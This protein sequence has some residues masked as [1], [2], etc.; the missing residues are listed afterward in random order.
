MRFAEQER[1]FRSVKKVLVAVS[2]GPDSVACLL[3]LLR[4]R[5]RFGLEVVVGHFDHQL[6]P[7]SSADLEFVRRLC[8]EHEIPCFTGEGDVRSVARESRANVEETA[9][10]MRYQFL[11]FVAGKENA[12][13]VATGHTSDDQA[14]TV[15]M[16]VV[17]G[18]GV[19]G[20]RGMLPAAS[21]PEGDALRLVRPLLPIRHADTVAICAE[22]GVEP[23]SD[24]TNRD[25]SLFRN[26]I[27]MEVLPRL[28]DVNPS[29]DDALLGLGASARQL[30]AAIER[31]SFEVQPVARGDRGAIFALAP[32]AALP[33]EALT[34]VIEREAA[35]SKLRPE[36]NRTRVENLRTAM[37]RGSG[38]ARFGDTLV[39]VSCGKVRIG[40]EL[41]RPVTF[42]AKA[43]NIPG[44]TLVGEWRVEATTDRGKAGALAIPASGRQ[45]ALRIRP[46]VPGDRVRYHGFVRKVADVLANAR[47]PRWQ[48]TGVLAITGGEVVLGLGGSVAI[49]DTVPDEDALYL[50]FVP[51]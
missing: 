21:V 16:R 25:P 15:L 18:S 8:A 4:L 29:V 31:R 34:L 38:G 10:R 45:G 42:E 17:R 7:E 44:A 51:I 28:R 20:V 3:L 32:I 47:V 2:G 50:R 35:F 41:G 26:R 30:F 12:D 33:A 43:L 19:R 5:K 36:V 23:L 49:A 39:E 6:R 37:A 24:P 48:R 14:E 22:A 27:R 13:C 40:P 11:S 46:V 9:R 1:L